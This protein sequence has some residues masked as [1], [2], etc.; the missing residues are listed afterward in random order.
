[1]S[2][3]VPESSFQ[4]INYLLFPS[5]C[6]EVSGVLALHLYWDKTL[7]QVDVIKKLLQIIDPEK[8]SG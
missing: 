8:S 7:K 6:P 4:L 1:M 2:A 3:F 5:Y